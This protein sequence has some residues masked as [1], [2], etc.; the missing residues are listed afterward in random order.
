MCVKACPYNA[1][2]KITVPCEESCPVS[3]IKKDETGF[4]SIDYDKCINCGRCTVA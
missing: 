4:A 1:I 3:A 2:V